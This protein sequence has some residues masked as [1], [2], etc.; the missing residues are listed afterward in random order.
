M[1]RSRVAASATGATRLIRSLL[2]LGSD[3]E[4]SAVLWFSLLGLALSCAIM[5]SPATDVQ[6][7]PALDAARPRPSGSVEQA[8]TSLVAPRWQP[9]T[10]EQ[11]AIRALWRD[12]VIR[13]F[14]GPAE[15]DGDFMAGTIPGFGPVTASP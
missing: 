15:N 4:L 6:T 12:P 2:A 11:R 3:R 1:Q 14:R 13:E 8:A 10:D 5:M 7:T 9:A